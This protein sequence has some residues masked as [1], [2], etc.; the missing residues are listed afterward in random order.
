LLGYLFGVARGRGFASALR[1]ELLA[2][3]VGL[4]ALASGDPSSPAVHLALAG[5][6]RGVERVVVACEVAWEASAT[7]PDDAL[8]RWRR[9]KPLLAVAQGARAKRLEAAWKRALVR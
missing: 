3:I 1:E 6:L 5:V 7:E 4:S 2:G 9:D 8:A